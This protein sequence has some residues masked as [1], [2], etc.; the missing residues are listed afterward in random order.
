MGQRIGGAP[1]A[2]QHL[3]G[4]ANEILRQWT[5]R[6]R[7]RD[8]RVDQARGIGDAGTDRSGPSGLQQA[9]GAPLRQPEF[10]RQRRGAARGRIDGVTVSGQLVADGDIV[11]SMR[12]RVRMIERFGKG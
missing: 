12:Q 10:L 2:Q 1:S 7:A 6:G 9:V 3:G 8:F 5:G 4:Q 11:Q